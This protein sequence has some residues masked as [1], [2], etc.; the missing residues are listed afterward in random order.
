MVGSRAGARGPGRHC[1][2]RGRGQRNESLTQG[3]QVVELHTPQQAPGNHAS[4][5]LQAAEAGLGG[6]SEAGELLATIG[7][8]FLAMNQA[9]LH[10]PI[11]EPGH[12]PEADAQ[13]LCQLTHGL[14]SSGP[15][16][17]E[18]LHLPDRHV[19]LHDFM[20]KATTLPDD[21]GADG[22]LDIATQSVSYFGHSI[23]L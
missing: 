4:L 23:V 20:G 7:R 6:W 16:D 10:Q 22:C 14:R 12:A 1:G 19:E 5:P 18:R 3:P 11:D 17:E 13:R 2:S 9:T 15:K 8:V 21:E